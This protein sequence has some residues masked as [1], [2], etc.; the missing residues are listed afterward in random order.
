MGEPG[1]GYL[2]RV[3]IDGVDLGE[4]TRVEGLG[5]RYD[6][7][8]IREGGENSHVH[9]LPGRIEYDNLRITRPVDDSSSALVAWFVEFQQQLRSNGHLKRSTAS[10][11]A[12]SPSGAE[13]ATWSL[14]GVFP[15]SYSG[16]T[17]EAGRSDMLVESFDL[18]HNGFW[19]AEGAGVGAGPSS[20]T[21]RRGNGLGGY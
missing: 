15:L 2:F 13:V 20:G 12:V 7:T 1:I 10:V 16:P 21:A 14:V 8:Q 18:V 19:S 3:R 9:L 6:V 11:T 5:A 4:F 17:L